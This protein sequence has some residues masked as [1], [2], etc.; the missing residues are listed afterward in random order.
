[1][2]KKLAEELNIIAEDIVAGRYGTKTKKIIDEAVVI[3]KKAANRGEFSVDLYNNDLASPTIAKD[4]SKGLR[5]FGFKVNVGK[6]DAYSAH[7]G[8]PQW[9]MTVSW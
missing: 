9:R 3:A 8:S 7:A 4:V 1:M 5:D 2:V 6:D